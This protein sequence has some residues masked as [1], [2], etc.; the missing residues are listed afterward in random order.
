MLLIPP[1]VDESRLLILGH[2]R[3]RSLSYGS[4]IF[5]SLR[6]LVR[7]MFFRVLSIHLE[8]KKLYFNSNENFE[9]SRR[10]FFERQLLSVESLTLTT[11]IIGFAIYRF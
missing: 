10:D 3:V 9:M 4:Q 11:T 6:D 1:R 5:L 7:F 8:L 2:P